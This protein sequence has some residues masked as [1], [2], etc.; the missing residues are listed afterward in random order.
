MIYQIR[1]L[2]IY[3]IR[4]LGRITGLIINRTIY[5][6]L[7]KLSDLLIELTVK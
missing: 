2:M 6:I 3:Q 7:L 4:L 5:A 1:L